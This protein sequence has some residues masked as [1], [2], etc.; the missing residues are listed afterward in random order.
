LVSFDGLFPQGGFAYKT[1]KIGCWL[2]VV[3][4]SQSLLKPLAN[5][6]SKMA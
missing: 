5:A 3:S 6:Q 2:L 1:S 4:C